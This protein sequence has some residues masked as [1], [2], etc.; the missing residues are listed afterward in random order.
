M[1][2]F[3]GAFQ[4]A[5]WER[6][7]LQ[8]RGCWS[9]WFNPWV[10]NISGVGNGIH[11]SILAWEIPW[12][13]EPNGLQ[14]I[15]SERVSHDWVTKHVSFFALRFYFRYWIFKSLFILSLSLSPLL[16][17]S[18][19]HSLFVGLQWQSAIF[20]IYQVD[21]SQ[22]AWVPEG[23]KCREQPHSLIMLILEY[24]KEINLCC[25]NLVTVGHCYYSMTWMI[26]TLCKVTKSETI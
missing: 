26:L 3:L 19:P 22:S 25:I 7:C 16:L 9:F 4:A 21:F 15:E 6:I 11:S 1:C 10:S 12:T 8:C 2:H 18:L 5:Q 23:D 20:Q 24:E 14:S 13:E 17:L